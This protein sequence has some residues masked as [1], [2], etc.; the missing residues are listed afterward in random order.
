MASH[1]LQ[2][3][4]RDRNIQILDIDSELNFT[5]GVGK[6]GSDTLHF[7]YPYSEP[8]NCRRIFTNRFS[9]PWRSYLLD[10]S[11]YPSSVRHSLRV[12]SSIFRSSRSALQLNVF[13]RSLST[14]RVKRFPGSLFPSTRLCISATTNNDKKTRLPRMQ[15]NNAF[16]FSSYLNLCALK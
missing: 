10:H 7:Q 14:I 9:A 13:S 16:S 4:W 1:W 8:F 15:E 2:A 12:F 6:Q 5:T 3:C 11:R